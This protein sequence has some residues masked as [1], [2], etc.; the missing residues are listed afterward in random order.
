MADAAFFDLDRTLLGEASGPV[1]S[2]A[3][4]GAGIGGAEFPLEP[5]LFKIFNTVGETLPSMVLA[6]QGASIL[7][8]TR[9]ADVRDAVAGAVHGLRSLLQ[10][11]AEQVIESH[12]AAGDRIVMATT[13]P[14]DFIL[15]FAEELGFDDV[16]ATKFAV[17]DDGR[18]T[19]ELD[20]PFVWSQGK[21]NAVKSWAAANGVS[22]ANSTAYSDS[23]YDAPLLSAVGKP[24]AVNPDARLSLLA[25]ARRWRVKNFDV[26]D[27]ISKIPV[28]GL[29]V[30]KLALALT[31]PTT[32][33]FARFKL[34]GIE[35]IPR[36]GP[37]ILV[38]N[39][40]SYFDVAAVAMAVA[41][42]GRT[43]RFLGKKE[44]FDAPIIG[45]IATA[46]GGIRVERGTGSDEPLLAAADALAVGEMVA[47]MPQGT[48][49]R[50]RAFF[51][52]VLKGKWGAARLAA[53][54]RVPVVP[55]G[56]WGTENV[57]PRNS[58]LPNVLNI[59]RP[60][61]VEVTV[62]SPVALAYDDVDADTTRIM[63][64]IMNLLPEESR[65]PIE[66]TDEQIRQ[67]SPPVSSK[68]KP[69]SPTKK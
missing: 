37:A 20:G 25:A 57:W 1:L 18:Y 34:S 44:V 45:Q 15:P 21:L 63:S 2:R 12:R 13:T 61:L 36:T 53:Q 39:H 46:M 51:D 23:F 7:V 62:G 64:A 40:R 43:V 59:T 48:I 33:P 49:P 55:I 42:S 19:G 38:G 66:P 11:Y 17:D 5:L 30:Q 69:V 4:R 41:R 67:A 31:R 27:G 24:F 52:P 60:P 10:P 3:L 47:I 29:E 6:R 22:L 9:Q 16:I 65:V 68:K 8:G 56:L 28:V 32:F 26:A 14:Y 35:N 54:A 50:G 58:R